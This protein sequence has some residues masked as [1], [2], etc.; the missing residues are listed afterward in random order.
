MKTLTCV[1][2]V[3][4]A[5][6][7]MP[8]ARA[9]LVLEYPT[10]G[11]VTSLAP[12]L[13]ATGV[14]GDD[15]TAGS[16]LAVQTFSTFNFADWDVASTTF[17]AAVAANDFWSWGFDVTSA[18]ASITPTTMDI[19]LDRS[20]TGPDDFEI[21]VSVNGG[22]ASTVLTHDFNDSGSGVDFLGVD[23]SSIGTL[24]PGDSVVFT[25]AAF[26]SESSAGTFDL[27]TIDLNGSD[28]RALRIEGIIVAVPEASAFLFGGL[29]VTAVGIGRMRR[30]QR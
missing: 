10:A 20:S 14:S 5:I 28:P 8:S 21:Q 2:L 22:T 15:L 1:S 4:M 24:T 19:R 26:N 13:E 18:V 11:S 27:E 12:S 25:L 9:D 6:G 16:G 7:L 17:G 29:A 30:R 23:I 3:A